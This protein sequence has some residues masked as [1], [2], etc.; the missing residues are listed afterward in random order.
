MAFGLPVMVR[1]H[2][3]AGLVSFAT[4]ATVVVWL[5]C[6]RGEAVAVWFAVAGL[7]VATAAG[8]ALIWL[9]AARGESKALSALTLNVIAARAA[10]PIV[11]S[12]IRVFIFL[13]FWRRFITPP[14][15]VFAIPRCQGKPAN[16]FSVNFV[17]WLK[18]PGNG[19]R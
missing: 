10:A 15:G 9:P 18:I 8:A 11:V 17:G 3:K 12:R 1:A 7:C 6:R 5:P 14:F 4:P 16:N 2:F 13:F 19:L